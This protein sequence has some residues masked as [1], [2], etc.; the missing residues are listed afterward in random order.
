[1]PFDSYN[2]SFDS[3]DHQLGIRHRK[4]GACCTENVF[5]LKELEGHVIELVGRRGRRSI[6]KQR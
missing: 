4:Y 3:S 1:M 6:T 2:C 5:T